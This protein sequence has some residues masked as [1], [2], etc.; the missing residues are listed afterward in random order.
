[1]KASTLFLLACTAATMVAAHP[2]SLECGTDATTRL[3]VGEKI[4]MASVADAVAP[5]GATVAV[6]GAKVTVTANAGV[7]FAVR[8]VGAGASLTLSAAD[9]A[10][11]ATTNCT[12]QIFY[13]GTGAA[14]G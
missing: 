5:F 3:R 1:M 6:S 10:L 4:M 2:S 11:A 7:F 8:A 13:N 12:S 14:A 9:T